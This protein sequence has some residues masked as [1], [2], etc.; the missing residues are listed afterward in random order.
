[1]WLVKGYAVNVGYSPCGNA[2]QVMLTGFSVLEI[3]N[4]FSTLTPLLNDIYVPLK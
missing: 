2:V 4:R 3:A 1:M